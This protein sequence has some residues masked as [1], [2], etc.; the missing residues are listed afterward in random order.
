M[1]FNSPLMF[2]SFVMG[3]CDQSCIAQVASP[4]PEFNRLIYKGFVAEWDGGDV[5]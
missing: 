3:L 1:T 5:V 2:Y 4:V